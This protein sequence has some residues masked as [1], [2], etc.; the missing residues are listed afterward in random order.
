MIGDYAFF[1]KTENGYEPMAS[2]L[3]IAPKGSYA[4]HYSQRLGLNCTDS[5]EVVQ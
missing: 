1:T 3:L 2:L 5:E 4:E